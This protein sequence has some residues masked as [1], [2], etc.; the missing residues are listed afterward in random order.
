MGLHDG[1]T[2]D[3]VDVPAPPARI[4]QISQTA[5]CNRLHPIEQR[6]CR[7]LLLIYDRVPTGT[8]QLTQE[9]IAHMLGVRRE[10]VTLAARRLQAVGLIRYGRGQLTILDHQGLE[11]L[12]CECYQVV[13]NEFT[14]R[15]G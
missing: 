8:V 7:W 11:A 6:L 9:F 5:V 3:T 2:S 10:G 13:Q 1:N 4:T 12:V 15:L 14:R